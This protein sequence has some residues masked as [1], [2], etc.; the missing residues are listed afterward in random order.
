LSLQ[1]SPMVV[2]RG[3]CEYCQRPCR[4]SEL[5]ERS[6]ASEGSVDSS[7]HL[8]CLM[9]VTVALRPDRLKWIDTC[10]RCPIGSLSNGGRMTPG[11]RNAMGI[12][13]AVGVGVE[14]F[15]VNGSS[16]RDPWSLDEHVGLRVDGLD[17][18][19]GPEPRPPIC[20][21]V[22]SMVAKAYVLRWVGQDGIQSRRWTPRTCR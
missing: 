11:Q 3:S 13:R 1:L 12:L 15:R 7:L 9:M 14:L 5:L 10:C 18:Q 6:I 22:C 21:Q 2:L 4:Y 20:I 8:E 17:A 16:E 19:P